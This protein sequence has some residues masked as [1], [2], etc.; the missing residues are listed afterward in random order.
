MEGLHRALAN[1]ETVIALEICLRQ[2]PPLL[3][4]FGRA[5]ALENALASLRMTLAAVVGDSSWQSAVENIAIEML[6][7]A[8]GMHAEREELAASIPTANALLVGRFSQARALPKVY[9]ASEE[10][11]TE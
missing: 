1:I 4:Y 10:L 2:L 9:H 11:L 7:T 5:E 6:Q 3:A 8:R